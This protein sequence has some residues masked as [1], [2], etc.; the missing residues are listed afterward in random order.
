MELER[1]SHCPGF[2]NMLAYT[3]RLGGHLVV[4]PKGPAGGAIVTCVMPLS[5]GE[6][7]G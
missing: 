6:Q 3:E 5:R 7:E 4:E 1:P 2:A